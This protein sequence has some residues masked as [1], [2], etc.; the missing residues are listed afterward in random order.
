MQS[1]LATSLPFLVTA[2]LTPAHYIAKYNGQFV[3]LMFLSLLTTFNIVHQVEDLHYLDSG[4]KH[5]VSFPISPT[6]LS[7]SPLTVASYV[8]VINALYC[9]SSQS[10]KDLSSLFLVIP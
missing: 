1:L 10:L 5:S 8:L 4:S 2:L 3:I 9:S 6:S 7:H